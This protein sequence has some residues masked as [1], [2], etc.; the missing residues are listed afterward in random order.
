MFVCCT[1][2]SQQFAV[3]WQFVTQ[4]RAIYVGNIDQDPAGEFL[5]NS[6]QYD[7][8]F[9]DAQ[10]HQVQY[11]VAN[12]A[13]Y[14]VVEDASISL[15]SYNNRFP[16]IDYNGNGVSDFIFVDRTSETNP[17]YRIID[18]STGGIIFQFPS[19]GPYQFGWLGDFDNDGVLE[20]SVSYYL[21]NG[22]TQNIVYSTGVFLTEAR[23]Q[24]RFLPSNFH[25]DQ[26][27]P[28]PFNPSTTIEYS[29]QHAGRARLEIYN[30]LGQLVRTLVNEERSA[31]QYSVFWDGRDDRGNQLPSGT[32]FYRLLIGDRALTKNMVLI[33]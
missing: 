25:L 11:T 30:S 15:S 27:Y 24:E 31:G 5:D 19:N 20:M 18:P 33:R 13:P 9:F 17:I 14:Q 10:T 23:D 26:N 12:T 28:N 8:R 7:V 16:N 29:V 3:D 1:S 22:T 6:F 21:G 32:Y 2:Y 4:N